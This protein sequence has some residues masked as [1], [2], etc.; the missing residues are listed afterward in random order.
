MPNDEQQEQQPQSPV[1]AAVLQTIPGR[2]L[3]FLR[4]VASNPIIHSQLEAVGFSQ[5]ENRLGWELL[6]AASGYTPNPVA[7]PEKSAAFK[8]MAELDGWDE[9]GFRR[10]RAALERLHPPQCTFVFA[11]D[12]VAST[13][14]A[15][16]LGV[17][18]L[19]DRLD[20]L[21]T[22]KDRKATRK[23]DH[24]ALKT[25]SDRK[26]A[27][28]EERERLRKLV[29]TAQTLEAPAPLPAAVDPGARQEALIKL[30]AWYKDWSQTAH[31]VI[32]K[33]AHQIT[34]GIAKRKS[35]R[36]AE[37]PPVK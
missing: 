31:S 3:D 17:K 8:A 14:T 12:L 36:K 2:T 23:D 29:E 7:P 24:A 6:H 5:A 30:Y 35:P 10:I 9:D 16:V 21:E 4:G 33:K 27:A 26:I 32:K 20:D 37:K 13:G 34:L 19:L 28:K 25:L 18:K 11:G 1:S 15:A 22:G